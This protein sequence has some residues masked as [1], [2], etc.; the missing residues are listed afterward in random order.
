MIA[1]KTRAAVCILRT[2]FN[3]IFVMVNRAGGDAL[4]KSAGAGIL[5]S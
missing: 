4:R 1:E 5:M 2:M 3:A